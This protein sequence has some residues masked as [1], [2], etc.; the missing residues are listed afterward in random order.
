MQSIILFLL[1]IQFVSNQNDI[2]SVKAYKGNVAQS[3]PS[4]AFQGARSVIP[5]AKTRVE[6]V[7]NIEVP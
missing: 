4:G 6:G 3:A 2:N 5:G 7:C 1:T